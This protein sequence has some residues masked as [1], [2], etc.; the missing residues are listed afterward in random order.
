MAART[1]DTIVREDVSNLLTSLCAYVIETNEQ[2]GFLA[3]MATGALQAAESVLDA[4]ATE[5]IRRQRDNVDKLRE[6]A[7][8]NCQFMLQRIAAIRQQIQE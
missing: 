1:I 2:V 5:P 4:D 6:V 7:A 3:N 8:H